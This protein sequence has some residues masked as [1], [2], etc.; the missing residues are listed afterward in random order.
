M[1][2]LEALTA[3]VQKV[4]VCGVNCG[5]GKGPR[6]GSS[7]MICSS[8]LVSRGVGSSTRGIV[9][10]LVGVGSF[11]VEDGESS[12]RYGIGG[13][14]ISDP[15]ELYPESSETSDNPKSKVSS[16]GVSKGTIDLQ[17]CD[18]IGHD[19]GR[20]LTL[21]D[22]EYFNTISVHRWNTGSGICS[23]HFTADRNASSF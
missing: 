10:G 17:V 7:G 3:G 6:R 5:V 23:F 2:S 21:A 15:G 20:P 1:H 11:D 19:L 12:S 9:Y 13:G 16:S 22:G 18:D 4:L 8:A 14:L